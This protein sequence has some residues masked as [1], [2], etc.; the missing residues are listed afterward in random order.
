MSKG[1]QFEIPPKS[2]EPRNI[3]AVLE[4]GEIKSV[5]ELEGYG[6]MQLVG[7]QGG[8]DALFRPNQETASVFENTGKE[9][10]ASELEEMAFKV[11]EALGFG[12]VPPVAARTVNGVEGYLQ[13][14][15]NDSQVA[16]LLEWRVIVKPEEL[17]KAAVFDYLLDV[18]DRR[19]DS[20]LINPK[21]G[22]IWLTGHDYWMFWNENAR[23]DILREAQVRGL[24]CLTPE[25]R[26]A[27]E[28]FLP[29]IDSLTVEAKKEVATIL[30]K[31]QERAQLI[32][33]EGQI[34]A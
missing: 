9:A 7:I 30:K 20:F 31:A 21:I 1:Q 27:L 3:E 29:C 33:S 4:K 12:L 34:P 23:S 14:F 11:D 15:I 2:N 26:S 32:L 5:K 19:G 6:D 28:R 16:G 10:M 22:K 8:G 13:Q 18:R 25:T 24:N 17:A